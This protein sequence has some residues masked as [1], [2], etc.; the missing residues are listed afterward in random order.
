MDVAVLTE[1]LVKKYGSTQA[2]NN[3]SLEV[4]EGE[5]YGLIGPDGSGKTSLFRILATLLIPDSG[6][7][8]VFGHCVVKDYKKIRSFTGYMPG[9]FSL[10]MDLSV[11]E[12]LNFYATVFG[13]SVR[14]NYEL[15]RPVFSKLEPFRKRLAGDLSGGMKQKLALSCALI[16]KPRILILDEPTTG[17]DAISRK[18]FWVLLRGLKAQGIT[19]LVSTPYMDEATLCDRVALVQRGN[20]LSEGKPP[21]II[22]EYR[23]DLFKASADDMGR[24]LKHLRDQSFV[25]SAHRFGDNIHL[26][27][28]KQAFSD[29]FIAGELEKSGFSNL[30]VKRVEPDMEDC[31]LE[32]MEKR[33]GTTRTNG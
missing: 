30:S 19:I 32:L 8:R 17:V 33:D 1:G 7:A 26:A 28:Q 23:N 9:R 12:N 10:Y 31:F 6:Y 27:T 3:L 4:A 16:H 29:T 21:Q 11:E 18:E 22:A 13:T 14:E 15:I 20:I 25:I 5:L 2:L 24:L